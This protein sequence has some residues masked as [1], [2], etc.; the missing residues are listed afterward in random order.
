MA[1][2]HLGVTHLLKIHRCFVQ[3]KARYMLHKN[4][5]IMLFDRHKDAGGDAWMYSATK[6][7]RPDGELMVEDVPNTFEGIHIYL[8]LQALFV[9]KATIG[10]RLH[11]MFTRNRAADF[12]CQTDFGAF[13]VWWGHQL[14]GA[15]DGKVGKFGS[16]ELPFSMEKSCFKCVGYSYGETGWSNT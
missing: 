11:G 13:N 15:F 16:S 6:Y 4:E 10:P 7:S 5:N 1:M 12:R 14:L 9:C 2:E 8:W 3:R